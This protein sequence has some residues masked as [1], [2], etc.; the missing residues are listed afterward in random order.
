MNLARLQ[1]I[2]ETEHSAL[3]ELV[4]EENGAEAVTVLDVGEELTVEPAPG[5]TP[6][7]GVSRVVGQFSPETDTAPIEHALREAIGD[8][9]V[10]VASEILPEADWVEAWRAYQKPR[11]FG[12]DL[13][14]APTDAELSAEAGPSA[15][16]IR[17]DPGLAFGTGS[18]PTTALCL[19]WLAGADLA[20]QRVLDYGCGSG[21]LA[22]AAAKLGA[23]TV[24]AVDNDPKALTATRDNAAANGVAEVVETPALDAVPEPAYDIVLANILAAPLIDLAPTL[25]AQLAPG[26]WLVL[27]GLL[28]RHVDDVQNAYADWLSFEP[29]IYEGDW[30]ALAGRR[31]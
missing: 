20:G 17:L 3:A 22:I 14:V 16:V 11:R 5:Q 10:T 13:W 12:D 2:A 15:T 23:H 30:A 26:G 1:V 6:S 4:L 24:V 29:P 28:S 25:I 9:H 19:A 27:S 7:F 31:R 21:I 8:P 18:H